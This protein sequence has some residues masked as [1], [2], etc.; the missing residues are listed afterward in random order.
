MKSRW[1][2]KRNHFVFSAMGRQPEPYYL[3]TSQN[4]GTV[5]IIMWNPRGVDVVSLMIILGINQS[6]SSA[7]FL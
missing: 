2:S 6:M 4:V 3:K 7:L 1:P 5:M